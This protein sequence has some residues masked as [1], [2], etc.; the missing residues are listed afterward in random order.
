MD[1]Y[2]HFL[3]CEPRRDLTKVH[4]L[5]VKFTLKNYRFSNIIYYRTLDFAM[6]FDDEDQH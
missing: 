3:V 2:D 1:L 6:S 4:K 5:T